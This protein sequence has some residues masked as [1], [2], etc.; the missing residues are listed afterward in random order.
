MTCNELEEARKRVQDASEV[1]R[2]IPEYEGKI[3]LLSQ[4]LERL[5]GV[6]EKK[7]SEIRAMG[8]QVEEM[9]ENLRISTQQHGRVNH[10]LN[11]YKHKLEINNQ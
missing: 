9:Q 4:E 1:N 6:V 5:N 11:D 8:G 7:N 10:E 2:R 3:A